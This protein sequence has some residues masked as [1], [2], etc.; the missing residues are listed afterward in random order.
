MH[1]AD[2]PGEGGSRPSAAP[3]AG[4]ALALLIGINLFNYIDRYV[5]A[6]VE[7][8]IRASLLA[9][10][11]PNAQG[12]TGLLSSAFLLSFMA[13][14]PLFGW[15]AGRY[16]RW[17][18]IAVG[19]TLW[20]VAS[21]ACGLAS[22]FGM[23]LV[24]RCFVGVGEGAYGPVAPTL[25]SDLYPVATRGRVMAWFYMAIP[26]GGA[27]GYALG[28][29][30]NAMAGWR[31]AFYVVVPPGLLLGAW[32]FL[33]RDPPQGGA[34]ALTGP[35]RRAT[36][37]E[38][39][40]L[41][42][43]P[44]FVLNTLGM[45]AMSFATGVLAFWMPAY[46]RCE[47]VGAVYGI[48]PTTVFGLITAAGGLTAT[49]A[50]G[51]AGDALR[52]RFPGS[53][54]LVSAA[55]LLISAPGMVLFLCVPFPWAWI[56]VF[57]TVFFLFFNTG[58]TNTILANVSHPAMRAT[59]FAVNILAIHLLGDVISPPLVGTLADGLNRQAVV[60]VVSVDEGSPAARAGL[61]PGDEILAVDETPTRLA[62][63]LDR[64]IEEKRPGE[65]V[66]M[67]GRR[68][69]EETTL[70]VT[71]AAAAPHKGPPAGPDRPDEPR[72]WLGA[73]A[74]PGNKGLVA[75]FLM[76]SAFM[77]LGAGFWLWGARYL[78]AD[79]AAAPHRLDG[80]LTAT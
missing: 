13:A 24:T 32:A 27:L 2:L 4:Y 15:L 57:V 54:F 65:T 6:A 63:D 34:D 61:A 67:R 58:P 18:L 26:F 56:F 14:A 35:P 50:G 44:S 23:L 74:Q 39:R 31:W 45:A 41:I 53:Y 3:G 49:L 42:R 60:R 19:V 79:T 77:V 36:L 16:A 66:Q 40:I 28:G 76:V 30:I 70:D 7:P 48:A 12:K 72:A 17:P 52:G 10:G 11:D 55:G 80:N 73:E 9:P 37:W 71:L 75:G 38:C 68:G 29:Q 33:M 25:L 21:G 51:M 78:A 47:K 20:T 1:D 5:L 22:T 64:L 69:G 43:T 46:L 8:E 59:A 62:V